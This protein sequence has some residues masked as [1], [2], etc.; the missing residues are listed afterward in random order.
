MSR[1]RLIR[2]LTVEIVRHDT[3]ATRTASGFDDDFRTMTPGV[4]RSELAP[5]RLLA[6]IKGGLTWDRLRSTAAGTLPDKRVTCI[7]H[8][9]DLEARGLI[10]ATNGGSMIRVGDKLT[11]IYDR[12]GTKLLQRIRDEDG[13]QYAV[14]VAPSGLGLGGDRNLLVVTFE[15]RTQ[16]KASYP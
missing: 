4:A 1:G 16:G 15:P 3:A 7:F 13:G 11:A 8:Y 6:Q 10:D 5:L 9:R 14:E 12:A 2:P